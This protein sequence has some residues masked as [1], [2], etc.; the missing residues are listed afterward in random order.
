MAGEVLGEKFFRV[1][2]RAGGET[3]S[4]PLMALLFFPGCRK[5]YKNPQIN[6]EKLAGEIAGRLLR[7]G[8]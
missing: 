5:K 3:K 2:G 6:K 7:T 8:D 1:W 4:F